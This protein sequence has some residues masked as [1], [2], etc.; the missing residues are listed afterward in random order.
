MASRRWIPVL[1]S[2]L[3]LVAIGVGVLV[4]L[5]VAPE[6]VLGRLHHYKP[7]VVVAVEG[8]YPGANAEVVAQT[9]AFPVEQQVNGVENMVSM[10]SQ[11]SND[12]RY[13]LQVT[14]RDGTD[15]NVAQMLV[16]N[17]TSLSV[18][19]L[20]AVVQQAG[21]TVRKVAPQPLAVLCLTSPDG[22]YDEMYLSNFAAVQIQPEL[23]RI[24]GVGEMVP[25][26]AREA[27]YR[28]LIDP[29]RLRAYQ[30]SVN[31]FLEALQASMLPAP[32]V[33][34]TSIDKFEHI[35]LKATPEGEI[36]R[37]S[38]VAR[39]EP[40]SVARSQASLNGQTAVVLAVYPLP[41]A[42]AS[43]VSRSIAQN[44]AELR[45]RFPEGLS[46]ETAFDFA[47]NLD[48]RG[49]VPLGEHLVIDVELPSGATPERTF[50]ALQQA[51][52]VLQ[53]TPGVQNVLALTEHPFALVRSRPCLIAALTP[54]AERSLDR[55][56][57]AASMRSRLKK[58]VAGA[59][60]RISVPSADGHFPIYGFPIEFV[61]EDRGDQ[62]TD[63]LL[64]A[65]AGMVEQMNASG[66]FTDVGQ[67]SRIVPVPMID[68]DHAKCVAMGIDVAQVFEAMELCL[69]SAEVGG[70][71]QT[72]RT[73]PVR[74][75]I[76]ADSGDYASSLERVRVKNQQNEFVP[77]ATVASIRGA[78]GRMVVE[79]HNLY[80]AARVTANLASGVPL[81]EGRQLCE[82]L[83]AREL[84]VSFKL[85]WLRPDPRRK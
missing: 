46:A 33:Q 72:A 41:E 2:V 34:F 79:R 75:A 6:L 11:S 77:L 63:V 43:D 55:A 42:R 66:K 76:D 69:G 24:V 78:T 13:L 10:S 45:A 82:S 74:A 29:D 62:P 37:L 49:H 23:A 4:L 59:E 57:V 36:V 73:W 21:V 14:F 58:E 80:P 19:A 15:P 16:Q 12:G 65:A 5:R 9:I 7:P 1:A 71:E 52:E 56:A 81:A 8:S 20:P 35:V 85:V 26:G 40:D 31:D 61:I 28:L 84:G 50:E 51:T 48:P 83:A 38:D 68:V 30:L 64:K 60:F 22:R 25:F 67:N 32:V 54:K 27:Q 18:P 17:R 39:I 3:V 47:P 70:V 44:L 53:K